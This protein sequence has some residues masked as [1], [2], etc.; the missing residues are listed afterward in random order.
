MQNYQDFVKKSSDPEQQTALYVVLAPETPDAHGDI[1][2]EEEVEKA[3]HSFMLHCQRSNLLHKSNTT[4]FSCVE[5][6]VLPFDTEFKGFSL[7][8]GT[9]LMKIKVHNSILWDFVKE[10]KFSGLSIGAMATVE[11]LDND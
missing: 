5:S 2:S 7:K 10:G 11:D 8:S 4:A 6:Y 1:Y 9:W 3:A